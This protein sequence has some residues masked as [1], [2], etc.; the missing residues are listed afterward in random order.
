MPEQWQAIREC[1]ATRS[2]GRLRLPWPRATMPR[3][4]SAARDPTNRRQSPIERRGHVGGESVALT[5]IGFAFDVAGG[6]AGPGGGGKEIK[7]RGKS[8]RKVCVKR[9][10]PL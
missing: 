1:R 10:F 6:A 9:A 8:T 4:R 5:Q 7:N 3:T 2:Q